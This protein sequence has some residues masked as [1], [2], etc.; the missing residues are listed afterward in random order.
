MAREIV[1]VAEPKEAWAHQW[2]DLPAAALRCLGYPVKQVPAAHLAIDRELPWPPGSIVVAAI[3]RAAIPLKHNRGDR[4][5]VVL[6]DDVVH[7]PPL[8]GATEEQWA[9]FRQ[10]MIRQLRCA[11]AVLATSEPLVDVA[12]KVGARNVVLVP[13]AA[14]P[15]SEWPRRETT[16]KRT[17]RIGWA[18]TP[19]WREAD[20][21]EMRE[22][23][24]RLK[25]VQWIFWGDAPA[26][27]PAGT[28]VIAY[29]EA[30]E[31]KTYYSRL[32]QLR[33]DVA[34]APLAPT[35][36]NMSRSRAKL[37]EATVGAGCPLIASNRG[38]YRRLAE[39]GAPIVTVPRDGWYE[40]LAGLLEDGDRRAA[41]TAA[42]RAWVAKHATIDQVA[43]DWVRALEAAAA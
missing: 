19:G 16:A 10:E 32:A 25:G 31:M 37:I 8:F 39:A 3:G 33:L 11:A 28:E 5:I 40:T 38:P 21:A 23:L 43:D 4:V 41:L 34:V 42:A 18:G 36:F 1:F 27:P 26:N 6:G 15:A 30:I 20:F 13:F 22:A 29:D 17:R 24:E 9:P 35:T 7:A 14:P 12:R 2:S